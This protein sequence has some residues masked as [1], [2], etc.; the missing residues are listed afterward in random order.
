MHILFFAVDNNGQ[1]MHD[2]CSANNLLFIFHFVFVLY[3]IKII[4]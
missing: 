2:C 4:C 3:K 1:K